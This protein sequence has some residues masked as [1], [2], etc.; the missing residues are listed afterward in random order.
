MSETDPTVSYV[1]TSRDGRPK[2]WPL[3]P[4]EAIGTEADGCTSQNE[5]RCFNSATG[6]Y[7]GYWRGYW[8]WY[9]PEAEE[10]GLE[11]DGWQHWSDNGADY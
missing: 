4:I 11:P 1:H 3:P 2:R 7:F 10:M 6:F 5:T 8:H 9:S